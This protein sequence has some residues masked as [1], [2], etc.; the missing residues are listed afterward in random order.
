MEGITL[1]E[2]GDLAAMRR[3][4]VDCGLED[5]GRDDEGILR[6]WGAYDGERLVGCIALERE[7]GL[8]TA[9]W[10]AVDA[11][12]RRRGIAARLYAELE[13]DARRRGMRR[14]WVTARTPAFFT[15]HGFEPAPPG[16]ESDRLLGD[17]P[18]CE[19]Y[20]RSCKPRALTKRLDTSGSLPSR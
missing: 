11:S 14:L 10:M 19:Q 1:R 20:D 17:C 2:L 9:N 18:G 7:H 13:R 4:G 16:P 5:S 8:D 6:A 12:Y 3:L 15:A